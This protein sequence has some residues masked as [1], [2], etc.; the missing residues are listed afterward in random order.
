MSAGLHLGRIFFLDKKTGSS[1]EKVLSSYS[2]LPA[3]DVA[4]E[5]VMFGVV[6][7]IL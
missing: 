1:G 4:Y 7:A 3:E 5:G 2:I 6:V